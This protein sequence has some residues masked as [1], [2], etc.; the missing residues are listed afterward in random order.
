MN[1]D[2][3]AALLPAAGSNPT[4]GLRNAPK[5]LIAEDDSV[6]RHR[7]QSFLEKWGYSVLVAVDGHEAMR[8]METPDRPRL[9]V[10]DR[11]MPHVDGLDV[12][13]SIRAAGIDPYVYMILLTSQGE[14]RDML[15]GFAAGADDYIVKPFEVEE[16]RAR[17]Q[18]GARIV[19]LQEELEAATRQ[20]RYLAMH[21]P[22]TN[23]LNRLAFFEMF[24]HEVARAR[25][26]HT[27]LA[28]IMV[29][30]DHFKQINDRFGHLVGDDVLREIARRMAS[31]LRGS[32]A[33]GRFGGEEFVIMAPH[34]TA[35]DAMNLA[36]RFR[37]S[38]CAEPIAAGDDGVTVTISLGCAA[39]RDMDLSAQLLRAAD[40]ALYKAK[41]S[42]R[43]R[44]VSGTFE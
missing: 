38:V 27:S 25:R 37:A 20:L 1:L 32:D 7:L 16:L 36:D 24:E 31:T 39:T 11:M 34:C 28:L 21:D 2:S 44:I 4:L 29:D 40:E 10:L 12:C 42:G 15:E 30:V 41:Q 14:Q 17:L 35:A 19:A 23:V 9:A 43:N 6:S 18:T 33:M 3:I 13:R 26:H 22:L 8:I 5:V